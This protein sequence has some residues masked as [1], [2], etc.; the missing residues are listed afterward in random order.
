MSH[1]FEYGSFLKATVAAVDRDQ[2]SEGHSGRRDADH[3]RRKNENVRQWI[4]I[5]RNFRADSRVPHGYGGSRLRRPLNKEKEDGGLKDVHADD[6]FEEVAFS[7]HAVKTDGEQDRG[8]K[9]IVVLGDKVHG[10]GFAPDQMIKQDDQGPPHH[11]THSR[12]H[13]ENTVIS[14]LSA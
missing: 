11:Q 1:P 9:V 5:T 13:D 10:L 7:D 8:H 3:D 12:F 4:D 14:Q 6:F 2:Q